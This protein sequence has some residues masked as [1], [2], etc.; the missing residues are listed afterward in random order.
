[1]DRD[2]TA[3]L[4]RYNY[5]VQHLRGG[6][7][8]KPQQPE[9]HRSSLTP[10]DPAS[11][12]SQAASTPPGGQESIGPVP[13][14]NIPGHHPDEEQDK[15]I[16]AFVARARERTRQSRAAEAAASAEQVQPKEDG[17]VAA[18]AGPRPPADQPGTD[19][20]PATSSRPAPER[21]AV[22]DPVPVEDRPQEADR[23]RP[24]LVPQRSEGRTPVS[25]TAGIDGKESTAGLRP[26]PLD[27]IP[28][29]PIHVVIPGLALLDA[30]RHPQS[31]WDEIGESRTG[32]MARIVMFAW[33][34]AWRYTSRI[35][36]RLE[37]AGQARSLSGS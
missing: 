1:V 33:L 20:P 35:K 24:R 32:W 9:L 37:A 5:P 8:A 12:K 25:G 14:D 7:V 4:G 16:E 15:P 26:G 30:A 29:L 6:A 18:A 23:S 13:E 2:T 34:G 22:P 21:A 10:A 17:G 31:S 28:N 36:P 27:A 3:A 19:R 11:A